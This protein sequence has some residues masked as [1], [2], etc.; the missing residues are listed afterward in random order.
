MPSCIRAWPKAELAFVPVAGGALHWI[1]THQIDPKVTFG[2]LVR[3]SVAPDWVATSKMNLTP[4]N[5]NQSH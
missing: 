1:W 3:E 5:P 2:K 4:D